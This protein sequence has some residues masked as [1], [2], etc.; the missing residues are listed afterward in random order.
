MKKILSII[1]VLTGFIIFTAQ[2]TDNNPE[3]KFKKETQD[4]GKVPAGKPECFNKAGRH[5]Y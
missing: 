2:Q 4:F 3:F 1:T 5:F